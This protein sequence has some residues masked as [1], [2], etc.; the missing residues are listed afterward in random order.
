MA[1]N[2][3]HRTHRTV[4]LA[5]LAALVPIA[6]RAAMFRV[7]PEH[8]SV[9]FEIRHIVTRVKGTFDTFSGTIEFDPAAPEAAK[10]TGSI[11]AASVDTKQAK[12]DKH[13]RSSDFFDV[14]K[15]PKI[16]FAS[17]KVTKTSDTAGVIEGNLTMHGVTKPIALQVEYLGTGEVY[18]E[19]KAGFRATGKL[20]RKDFGIVWNDTLD[21]GGVVLGD[22]VEMTIDV[23]AA[24][25][26]G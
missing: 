6:S 4:A 19:T 17:T 12:R 25:T 23:E 15:F 21:G 9:T 18:G 2:F 16:T 5:V 14:Q 13:L 26:G 8:T 7:D 1:R 24:R 3:H 22:E 11:D 20:D 10:V